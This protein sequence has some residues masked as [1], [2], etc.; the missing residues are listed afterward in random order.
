MARSAPTRVTRPLVA[1]VLE[2][3]TRRLIAAPH[4]VLA[5]ALLATVFAIYR[6][7]THLEYEPSRANLLENNGRFEQRWL[8]YL[9]AFGAA[10]DA[11]FVVEGPSRAAVVGVLD[12]LT[13]R[14]ERD[15]RQFRAMI[16]KVDLGDIR[17]R[18][19]AAL[20]PEELAEIDKLLGSLEP[21]LAGDWS[22]VALGQMI[23]RLSQRIRSA[24]EGAGDGSASAAQ[25]E[26]LVDEAERLSTSLS[27]ALDPQSRYDSPWQALPASLTSISELRAKY[28]LVG[29]GRTGFVRLQILGDGRTKLAL[30]GDVVDP[31]RGLAAQLMAR[32]AQVRI[33]LT[34]RPVIAWDERHGSRESLVWAT[35]LTFT[36]AACL[37]VA[38]FGG[39]RYAVLIGGA[40]VTA[41]IWNA[42]YV[43]L[44]LGRV[45]IWGTSLAVAL[46]GL[47]IGYGVTYCAS[48]L[49]LR[50]RTATR[51]QALIDSAGRTGPTI[52]IGAL[53]VSLALATAA[54]TGSPG[55]ANLA[56]VGG[57]GVLLGALA[58]LVLVP[59]ILATVDRDRAFWSGAN[60]LGTPRWLQMFARYR[61]VALIGGGV[62]AAVA[63]SGLM[64]VRYESDLAGAVHGDLE[65]LAV[66]R[67]LL[68]GAR[69]GLYAFS[70]A[71]TRD[72]L[73]LRMAGFSALPT[74]AGVEEIG[75]LAAATTGTQSSIAQRIAER[76]EELPERPPVLG[77][78][79]PESLGALLAEVQTLATRLPGA[80]TAASNFEG[81]RDRLRRLP[82]ADCYAQLSHLQQQM[83]GDLLS[84]L[85]VLRA[86]ALVTPPGD[87]ATEGGYVLKVVGYAEASGDAALAKFV[88]DVRTVDAE[89]TGSPLDR[90]DASRR[91]LSGVER[92]T[93]CAIVLIGVL[94][95]VVVRDLQHILL[96]LAPV[97][98][99]IASTLGLL[100]WLDVALNPANLI[101]LPVLLGLSVAGSVHVLH[102]L[103]HQQE[104]GEVS[105]FGTLAFALSTV[106]TTVALATL[107]L[108]P[109]PAIQSVGLVLVVGFVCASVSSFILIPCLAPLL[110][111]P[112]SGEA[113]SEVPR[114][115][116]QGSPSVQSR[117]EWSDERSLDLPR[118]PDQLIE[119]DAETSRRRRT[120][121]AR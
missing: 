46:A 10:D 3:T 80:T 64:Y 115:R 66:Q 92:A 93:L 2:W 91:A 49:D 105:H 101:A 70:R 18:G 86:M 113:F 117:S 29:D 121:A 5:L 95:A 53:A 67:R 78:D 55:G 40:L 110:L 9:H 90:Y 11:V 47:G 99:G 32:H 51:E 48:Y 1:S 62:A 58:S 57:G 38:A 14:L 26:T 103:Q 114:P 23:A 31:L 63:I 77:V 72:E 61:Q 43:S 6:A 108:A 88:Y 35:V 118:E 4:I 15:D 94:L 22:E 111:H 112:S 106:I 52:L 27:T 42:G 60:S 104:S 13:T 39:L 41:V 8:E 102:D 7:L 71:D 44:V 83:A 54:L 119:G 74:I 120:V 25:V 76:L 59:A 36:T 79:Q 30:T 37:V 28:I 56:V 89:A 116:M 65:S 24:V 73:K 107:L 84:R 81:A 69:D 19:L 82:L 96:V 21:V 75:P 98:C 97:A 34:G 12:E 87:E 33:G 45:S 100:G 85:H 16:R 50:R 17:A 20:R 109:H 68:S